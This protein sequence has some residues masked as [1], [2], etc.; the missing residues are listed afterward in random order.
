[1]FLAGVNR[2]LNEVKGRILSRRPLPSIRDVFSE[3]RLEENK[4]KIMYS[5]EA[6]ADPGAEIST[7]SVRGVE[8]E[9]ERRKK[10]WCDY[11]KKFWH[12][13]ESCWKI[14]GKP[15]GGKKRPERALQTVAETSQ[16]QQIN[17][18]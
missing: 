11:C 13:R 2:N 16:E 18:G 17:S 7:L 14:H 6:S 3:V 12:T 4:R 1:M 15:P 5:N 9:G 8:S 10:P